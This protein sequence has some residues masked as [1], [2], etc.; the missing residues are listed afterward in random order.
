[1]K[2]EPVAKLNGKSRIFTAL[3]SGRNRSQ[4]AASPLKSAK[5]KSEGQK[6]PGETSGRK[7]E[8]STENAQA[9]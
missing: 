3:Q 2:N 6:H 7:L 9:Q 1:V 8:A 4:I 5:P